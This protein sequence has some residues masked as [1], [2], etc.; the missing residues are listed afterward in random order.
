MKCDYVA[1]ADTQGMQSAG[2]FTRGVTEFSPRVRTAMAV[3]RLIHG[4]FRPVLLCSLLENLE[5]RP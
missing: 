4:R 2:D 3:V 1:F 5:E